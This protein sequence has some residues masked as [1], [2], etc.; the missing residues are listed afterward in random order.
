VQ[1]FFPAAS[2]DAWRIRT[3]GIDHDIHVHQL[4]GLRGRIGDPED[5][6]RGHVARVYDD[7]LNRLAVPPLRRSRRCSG[8]IRACGRNR[9]ACRPAR[10]RILESRPFQVRDQKHP[11]RASATAPTEIR[12]RNDNAVRRTEWTHLWPATGRIG[13][14]SHAPDSARAA[15]GDSAVTGC[16]RWL[17]RGRRLPA[18]TAGMPGSAA[19]R[20]ACSAVAGARLQSW[21]AR[22]AGE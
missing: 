20:P 12:C 6:A 9:R 17:P 16:E 13:S 15:A 14:A 2:A 11:A 4:H 3:Y 8:R 22:D 19:A 5:F 18:V 21:R 10:L 1:F 7:V